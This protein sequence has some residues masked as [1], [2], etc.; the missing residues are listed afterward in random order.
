M[1]KMEYKGAGLGYIPEFFFDLIGYFIPGC[2]FLLGC[3][4]ILYY[5]GET[6]KKISEFKGILLLIFIGI[7]LSYVL[8]QLLSIVSRFLLSHDAIKDGLEGKDTNFD[9][10]SYFFNTV[11]EKFFPEAPYPWDDKEKRE[12]EKKDYLFCIAERYIRV[13]APELGLF[14]TKRHSIKTMSR[15]LALS[16]LILMP[17]SFVYIA[18]GKP[19]IFIVCFLVTL[20]LFIISLARYNHVSNRRYRDVEHCF[21][22]IFKSRAIDKTNG[23]KP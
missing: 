17:F 16:F 11:Q 5:Q 14:I 7:I 13:K 22:V 4:F 3:I 15:N 2:T 9:K 10:M 8:G 19:I 21:M 12:K 18:R 1:E 20:S 6:F 23:V